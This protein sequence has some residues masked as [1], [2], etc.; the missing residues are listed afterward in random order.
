L[1]SQDRQ[2]RRLTIFQLDHSYLSFLDA[3]RT[4]FDASGNVIGADVCT[5][6]GSLSGKETIKDRALG[7][8]G[9]EPRHLDSSKFS[10]PILRSAR[11]SQHS[12]D[13][14]IRI[15]INRL[16]SISASLMST[17]QENFHWMFS[18]ENTLGLADYLLE[19]LFDIFQGLFSEP[20]AVAESRRP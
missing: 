19:Q 18:A 4:Q 8:L 16:V 3:H 1:L 10:S 15:V 14:M 2:I 13:V 11:D 6:Q 7:C 20:I 12:G 9:A 17:E 5:L